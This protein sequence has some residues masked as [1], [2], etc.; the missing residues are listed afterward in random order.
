MRL[1]ETLITA[2]ASAAIPEQVAQEALRKHASGR[3]PHTVYEHAGRTFWVMT[4]AG[5]TTVLLPE[6][7]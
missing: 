2:G 1:G 7:Y 6:E 4:A 3:K 5:V